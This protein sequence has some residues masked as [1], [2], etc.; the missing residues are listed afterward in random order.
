MKKILLAFLISFFFF[1]EKS[2]AQYCAVDVT[3]INFG[4]INLVSGAP[5]D[6]TATVT[7]TCKGEVKSTLRICS[8]LGSGSGGTATGNPRQMW[9]GA[10]TLD[11][12]LYT[13]PSLANIWGSF[14]WPWPGSYPGVQTTIPL[15]STGYSTKTLTIYARVLAG[16]SSKPSG[17]YGTDF[18]GH[19][20]FTYDY[21]Y[22]T[23]CKSPPKNS[24]AAAFKVY[25]TA[26]NDCLVSATDMDFGSTGTLATAINGVSTITTRCTTGTPYSI[27]LS[28]GQTGT[29]PT[30][31]KMTQGT[32]AILYALYRDSARTLAWG[33][34]IG[35]N[36]M[37]G[38]GI[39]SNQN[40]SVYG[41]VPTQATPSG[42]TYTDIVNVT[43]TY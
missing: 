20:L 18:T 43:V 40:F 38:T 28:N 5:Y 39:G 6:T 30:T 42:G 27:S 15:G 23:P 13:T 26:G 14:V 16:Q 11:Y 7:I 25:G 17:F 35:T 36:T 4:T 34:A 21:D 8:S 19:T 12:S 10:S 24:T 31:R 33:D 22:L 41:K 37:S 29:S 1:S 3:P 2:H 9:N 32:G